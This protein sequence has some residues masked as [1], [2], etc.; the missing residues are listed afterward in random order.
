MV[1]HIKIKYS[2]VFNRKNELNNDGKALI[3][4]R[5]YQ[6]G[7]SRFMTTGIYIEPKYWSNKKQFIKAS[8]HNHSYL[9]TQLASFSNQI[10]QFEMDTALREGICS[11]DRLREALVA[12]TENEKSF[13]DFC[14]NHLDASTMEDSSRKSYQNTINK[15]K[16]YKKRTT[17]NSINYKFALGFDQFLRIQEGLHP[18]TVERQ[19][20]RLKKFILE[21]IRQ[22][23]IQA[24]NNPYIKFKEH[25]QKKVEPTRIYVDIE[26]IS[27]IENIAFNSSNSHLERVRDI[28]LMQCYT[29]LRHCDISKINSKN[30][31]YSES[32]GYVLEVKKTQK[33]KKRLEL[34]LRL[35]FKT[36]GSDQ[37]RPERIVDKYL[38]K[39]GANPLRNLFKLSNQYYNRQLKE[40]AKLANIDKELSSHMARRGFATYMGTKVKA[41]IVQKILQHSKLDMTMIYIQLSNKDVEQQLNTVEWK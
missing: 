4:L 1:N 10:E 20:S 36:E 31:H 11:V 30:L 27:R 7:I 32:R 38:G 22:D 24:K 29:G 40:I 9:N 5:A 33:T 34:P 41:T 19:H 23:R 16:A 14:Q 25:I 15:L 39:K 12:R 2:Y 8:Y 13:V 18:N 3:Q 17:F 37:S 35:L 6:N 26:E 21:A 28:F